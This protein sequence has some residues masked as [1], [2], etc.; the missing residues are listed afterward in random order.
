MT[1]CPHFC[2]G[3]HITVD[4]DQKR[5]PPSVL[6]TNPVI[7]VRDAHWRKSASGHVHMLVCV[8][9]KLSLP[10][11]FWFRLRNFD[12]QWRVMSDLYR[13]HFSYGNWKRYSTGIL[14]DVKEGRNAGEWNKWQGVVVG[15][16]GRKHARREGR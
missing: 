13:I 4:L 5:K 10:L 7:L 6:V 1:V 12:D 3:D 14:F 2:R 8:K 16:K 15:S 9:G 11:K